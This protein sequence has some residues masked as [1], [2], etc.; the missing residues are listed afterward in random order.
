MPRSVQ[1]DLAVHHMYMTKKPKGRP[2]PKPIYGPH[3]L[4]QWRE[5]AGRRRGR[6][7]T[8]EE[9]GEAVK[10]SHAQLGRIERRL[11]KYNQELLEALAELYKTEP[12]S[13]IM[14]DPTKEDAMWSLWDQAQKAEREKIEE[15]AE[16]LVKK[17][18]GT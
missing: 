11:Q 8:L 2:V 3:F 18:T 17:R 10:I 13:L 6:E 5:E 7:Y 4:R 9:V 16:L 1:A 15:Y 12:A 14:R